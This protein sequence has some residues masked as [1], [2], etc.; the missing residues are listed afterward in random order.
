[1]CYFVPGQDEKPRSVSGRILCIA[2]YLTVII[3]PAAYS[4]SL[5]SFLAVQIVELPFTTLEGLME[6]GSYQ[7]GVLANSSAINY[8]DVSILTPWLVEPG[9]SIIYS[10]GLSNKTYPEPNQPT[11]SC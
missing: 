2:T 6:H 4:A 1:M 11:S 9:G 7:L 10:Q 3:L 8:F 5:I